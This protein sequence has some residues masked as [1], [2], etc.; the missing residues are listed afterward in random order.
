MSSILLILSGCSSD[1]GSIGPSLEG[2]KSIAG[3]GMHLLAGMPGGAGTADGVGR[4]ARFTSPRSIVAIGDTL[5]IADQGNHAIRMVYIP[6]GKVV[7]LAGFPGMAGVDDGQ[8]SNARFNAP[9][10]ITTDGQYLYVA[11][12]GNHAIRKIDPDGN[13]TTIAGRR[14]QAGAR[15]GAG[16]DAMFKA[17]TGITLAGD[18]LYVADTDNHTIRKVNKLT[19]ETETIAGSPG[20][21]GSDDGTGT[22]ARFYYPLGIDTDGSYL[23]IAD[24]YNHTIRLMDLSTGDVYTIAGKAGT[25]GY[26]DGPLSEALFSYPYGLLRMDTNLYVADLG[27]GM[28]RKIDFSTQ[29]VTTVAG[30][31]G[32]Y[33]SIDGPVDSATF[34]SPADLTYSGGMLYIVDMD[35]HTLRSLDIDKGEVSTL[36]GMA[37]ASGYQDG[38]GRDSRFNVP[39]GLTVDG[40]KLYVAD[41][42]N[43]IIRSIDISTGE[44]TTLVGIPG[45]SGTTDSTESPALFN[46][47]SSAIID[48]TGE[49]IYIIDRDN[50]VIRQ[51]NL[52]TGKVDL[53]AGSPGEAGTSD[54]IG[55]EARFNSPERG[56]RIGNKLYITD[57][58]NHTIRVI[59]LDTKEV[60]TL[61][62]EP[63][64]SGWM[65]TD[66]DVNGIAKFN[67]PSD[68]TTDGEYLYVADTGNH[69]I[70]K[71]DI[72]TGYTT[73]VAGEKGVSGLVDSDQGAP[74]FS[75]PQGIV[76][77]E[78]VLYVADTENHLIRKIDLSTGDVSFLAGDMNCTEE[79]QTVSGQVTVNLKCTGQPTGVSS[80]TDSTDGTGKTA[81]FNG[82]T[83][84][85]TDGTYLYVMDTGNN[86]IRRVHM[87]TGETRTFTFS[88]NKGLSLNAPSGGDIKDH[89]IYIAD[90]GNHIIRKLDITSLTEAPL[91]TIAGVV[92]TGGYRN[93]DGYAALFNRPIGIAAD[94]HGNLYVA[95][96]AN[97]TIRKVNIATRKVVTISGIPGRA[98]FVNSAF[99]YPMFNYPRGLC[100]VGNH[101]YVADSGNHLIRRINI[102]NGFVGLVAGLSDYVKGEG[103]PGTADSTGAAAG[104]RDPRGIAC[105]DTYLY[106]AD[107]GNHTVRKIL[108]ATGQVKTI[109]GM[110]GEA[111]YRDGIGFDARFNSPRGITVDGDYIYVADTGN[112]VL[113]RIN[114]YT[115]EVLTLAGWSRQ[116]TIKEGIGAEARFNNVVSLATTSYT[117]YIFFTDSV[118]NVV[119][120]VSKY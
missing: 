71:V 7:T 44:V 90:T 86:K 20:I 29:M 118:E 57:T 22:Q 23:Y 11:D 75:S 51:M 101:L 38:K 103:S 26:R 64:V 108:R 53:L 112:N 55:G 109:A 14:G 79:R 48:D 65:D 28:I 40:E 117:P 62:G 94:G 88:Q 67:S 52:S 24:T 59:N 85:M 63:G 54:G 76:W 32:D 46:S 4:D 58:G 106:V 31:P 113:R 50:H 69:A 60:Y 18:Y 34:N 102:D 93:S 35:S 98:G 89:I 6:T 16:K 37:P 115:G 73:T 13:V 25:P 72:N 21:S 97:H 41:T 19:G 107:T 10:G 74:R 91:V 3:G 5:F 56:I 84:L 95:D 49:I 2:A 77:Y 81:S 70:R 30:I 111:G 119:G 36:A 80:Y 61:A 105:E 100:I 116:A 78:G 15:D 45:I 43:H 17:P 47:P 83:G 92:G 99:G 27:N 110:P 68:I 87:A 114:K 82:P 39:G 96:T 120:M 9:E 66:E 33:S 1:Y 12:T 104:F 42:F 8:G